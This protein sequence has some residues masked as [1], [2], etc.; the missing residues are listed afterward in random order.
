[1]LGRRL[2]KWSKQV[3]ISDHKDHRFMG[4][5]LRACSLHTFTKKLIIY[6]WV[7][8]VFAACLRGGVALR[9]PE[10]SKRTS[11]QHSRESY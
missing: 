7:G 9:V 5:I 11:D 1:M 4:S 3:G 6:M 2:G 8:H 10:R